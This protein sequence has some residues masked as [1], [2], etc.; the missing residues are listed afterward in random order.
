MVINSASKRA[1]KKLP[2]LLCESL[3]AQLAYST[4]YNCNTFKSSARNL[5]PSPLVKVSG[6]NLYSSALNKLLSL[7]AHWSTNS[8]FMYQVENED[9]NQCHGLS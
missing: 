3:S 2:L 7:I 9:G 8:L 1:E 6:C 5:K 4:L